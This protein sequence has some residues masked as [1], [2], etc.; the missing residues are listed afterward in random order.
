MS[1][2]PGGITSCLENFPNLARCLQ[3][4]TDGSTWSMVTPISHGQDRGLS[5]VSK[6]LPVSCIRKNFRSSPA[7]T[8]GEFCTSRTGDKMIV[9]HLGCLHA[10]S[11]TH[12]TL[13]TSE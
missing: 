4:E 2:A 12:L 1:I 3:P 9:H 13:P 10:V 11:Y 6:F 5:I 8:K 7:S